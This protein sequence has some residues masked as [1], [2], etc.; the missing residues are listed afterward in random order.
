MCG[1]KLLTKAIKFG[2]KER[3]VLDYFIK[4]FGGAIDEQL[5][6]RGQ[7]DKLA[8]LLGFSTSSVYWAL[9]F[10][11]DEGYLLRRSTP[12]KMFVLTHKYQL[13]DKAFKAPGGTIPNKR[14]KKVKFGPSVLSN[15]L[16]Q[17]VDQ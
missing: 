12:N 5:W 3:L 8:I 15:I 2:H 11:V 14:G 6:V 9:Q 1:G 10:L 16:I 7:Q 17:S 4:R 13:P